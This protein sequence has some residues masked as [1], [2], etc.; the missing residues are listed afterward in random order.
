M[1]KKSVLNQTPLMEITSPL[2]L[3]LQERHWTQWQI[4]NGFRK[5]I[6]EL[7]HMDQKQMDSPAQILVIE[8]E[9]LTLMLLQPYPEYDI[10]RID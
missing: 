1:K 5:Q 2:Q 7:I 8:E 9:D 10:Y 3:M 4:R 6:W